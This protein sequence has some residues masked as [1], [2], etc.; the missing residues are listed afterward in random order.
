MYEIFA[1]RY[2]LTITRIDHVVRAIAADEYRADLLQ[3]A[4]GTPLLFVGTTTY[5]D[6]G[7]IIEHTASYYRA[8][9]Y[10]YSTTQ[11]CCE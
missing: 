6:D 4:E 2:H 3:V 1:T 9:R 8:D 11:T 7:Q 10:E 5:L